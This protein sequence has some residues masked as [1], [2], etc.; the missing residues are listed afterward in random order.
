MSNWRLLGDVESVTG[1]SSDAEPGA[2]VVPWGDGGRHVTT[3]PAMRSS[4]WVRA[5]PESGGPAR[6]DC[7]R[8]GMSYCEVDHDGRIP[9]RS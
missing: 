8:A 1:V 2:P 3:G 4:Q 7:S 6:G 5:G 9:P